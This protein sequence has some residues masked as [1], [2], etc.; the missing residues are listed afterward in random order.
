MNKLLDPSDRFFNIHYAASLHFAASF[1]WLIR[2]MQI[3]MKLPSVY[4]RALPLTSAGSMPSDAIPWAVSVMGDRRSL[5]APTVS[6]AGS[7]SAGCSILARSTFGAVSFWGFNSYL[8]LSS[9]SFLAL[10]SYSF[11]FI[12]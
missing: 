7:F 2:A 9:A 11:L 10:S 1:M 12:V 4:L 5:M 6:V 3:W 8:V